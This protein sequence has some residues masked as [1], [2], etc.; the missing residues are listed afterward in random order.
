MT[1]TYDWTI[2]NVGISTLLFAA[3]AIGSLAAILSFKSAQKNNLNAKTALLANLSAEWAMLQFNWKLAQALV[4]GTDDYYAPIFA[5]QEKLILRAHNRV[6]RHPF[7]QNKYLNEIKISIEDLVQFF[8]RLSISI[9]NGS[10]SPVDVYSLL[11]PDVARHSRVVR[12][13]VG[14]ADSSLDLSGYR[15]KGHDYWWTDQLISR[16]LGGR[17][18]RLIYLTDALWAEIVRNRDLA[19]HNVSQVAIHKIVTKSGREARRRAFLLG[20][21]LRGRRHGLQLSYHLTF[22]EWISI[23]SLTPF[24]KERDNLENELHQESIRDL[25]RANCERTLLC[26]ISLLRFKIVPPR[27][28]HST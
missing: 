1:P 7:T 27:R 4:R 2:V 11:G 8:D 26:R 16:E 23:D 15:I 5:N 12:W 24:N 9:L 10:L 21:S 6:Q 17:R 3:T 25:K 14:A 22:A 28:M 18:A 20:K 13:T 19:S